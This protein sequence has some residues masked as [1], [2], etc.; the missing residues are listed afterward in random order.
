MVQE[1]HQQ[2]AQLEGLRT[3]ID[4]REHVHAEADLHLG[5]L[6]QRVQ[7]DL[8]HFTALQIDDDADALSI[9]FVAQVGDALEL[10]VAHELGDLFDQAG[11]VHLERNLGDDDGLP[12][13]LQIFE[14]GFGPHLDRAAAPAMEVR[15]TGAA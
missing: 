14:V 9:R 5:H 3:T 1:V 15:A 12:V 2:L 11:L 10:L 6:V 4:D 7:D 13:A 8:R